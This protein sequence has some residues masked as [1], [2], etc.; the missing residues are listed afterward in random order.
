MIS[1]LLILA[2]ECPAMVTGSVEIYAKAFYLHEDPANQGYRY[3]ATS[4]TL[5]IT[6]DTVYSHA[7]G[8]PVA[9]EWYSRPYGVVTKTPFALVKTCG[10]VP[11]RIFPPVFFSG[12]EG[13]NTDAWSGV[14][15]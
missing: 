2:L 12:F 13:G 5:I 4:N 6:N 14:V 7:K 8:I 15:P 1:L 9:I 10:T 11:S 3:T